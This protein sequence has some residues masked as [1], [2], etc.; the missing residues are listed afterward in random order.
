[1]KRERTPSFILELSLETTPREERILTKR[2]EQ[3]G[4]NLYNACLGE[5]LERGDLRNQS[6]EY[7]R[8]RRMPK[9][10]ERS[11]AFK[12]L[13]ARFG[14]TDYDLQAYAREVRASCWIGEHLD[15]HAAQKIATRAFDA[16]E[17]YLLGK[18]GRPR[19]KRLGEMRSVEGKSNAAGIRFRDGRLEWS[20]LAVPCRIDSKDPVHEWGLSHKVKYCRVI[21]RRIRGH[22]RW[23]LQLVLE[24]MPLVKPKNQP[25]EGFVGVDVGPST[26]AAVDPEQATLSTF[27]EELLPK[28]RKIRRL[29][30]AL[31]RSRRATNPENF[32]PDGTAK[33]GRRR[34]VRSHRYERARAAKA[35]LERRTGAHRKSLH[36]SMANAILRRGKRVRAEGVPYRAW[37]K[38][39]GRSIGR[40]APAMFM[41]ILDR[42]SRA[43]GGGLEEISTRATRLSQTCICGRVRKKS[44]SERVHC[45]ECGI[46]VQRDLMSAYLALH[47]K[48]NLLDAGRASEA[49]PTMEPLL[50][51]AS[52]GGTRESAPV[53]QAARSRPSRDAREGQSGSPAESERMAAETGRSRDLSKIPKDRCLRSPTGRSGQDAVAPG[54]ESGGESPGKARPRAHAPPSIRNRIWRYVQKV[55][56]L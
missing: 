39:W 32:N 26:I 5:A 2:I 8:V 23:Y 47:V 31:D 56:P 6:R 9:G 10:K 20:G 34:W 52:S 22:D 13:D 43:A 40:R 38:R 36:G 25:S 50:R 41:G 44:L 49:W 37:Q 53:N 12:A 55:L 51:A 29:Q 45:C 18:R 17:K 24:G 33:K 21:H 46:E 30:R 11:E 54:E 1:M 3:A 48:D 15:T 42:K 4:R 16:V 7:E 35:E 14:L 28:Q 27:C 19:F